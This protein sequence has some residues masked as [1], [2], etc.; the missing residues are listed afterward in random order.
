MLNG[1]YVMSK[2]ATKESMKEAIMEDNTIGETSRIILI[3]N[4]MEDEIR[5]F[6]NCLYNCLISFRNKAKEGK[7]TERKN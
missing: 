1:K 3:F 7:I 2:F 4:T 5:Q 6:D